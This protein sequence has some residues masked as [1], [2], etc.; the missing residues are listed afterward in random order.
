MNSVKNR[1]P[2]WLDT[3]EYPFT[4]HTFTCSDG[5]L[6]YI[7]IGKGDPIVF[8]H[9]NPDWSFSYRGIIKELSQY[10]RCIAVDHLG[11]GLSD[12][13][14]AADYTPAAH[15]RRL[16]QLLGSLNLTNI[17]L[18]MN[19][20][21]GPIGM[22]YAVH[23]PEDIKAL[24]V[25]NSWAWPVNKDWYYRAFSGL[26]GGAFGR[27]AIRHWNIF[28]RFVVPAAYGVKAKLTPT[29]Q[30]HLLMPF[31]DKQT[32]KGMATFPG[33]I[34]KQ[35]AWLTQIWSQR[36]A[37][38]AK[39]LLIA[40]GMKDIAFRQKELQQWKEA[41]THADVHTFADAGHFPQEEYPHEIAQLLLVFLQNAG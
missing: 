18:V 17:T 16:E 2:A 32:R 41:F 31:T 35:T 37:L 23:H 9:G 11:F 15:A 14:E 28:I 25:M 20:W 29:I 38:Q 7:D 26:M 34:I 39:P 27:Y 4:S 33:S 1:Q 13:P 19:D 24:V 10:Y 22:W 36:Q 21:G 3:K 6:H 12:K 40:W 8:V 30:K 5:N